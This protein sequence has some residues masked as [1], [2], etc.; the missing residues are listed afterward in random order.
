VAERIHGALADPFLV[1]GDEVYTTVSTGIAVSHDRYENP[2][3]MLRDAD[4]AMYQAK[5]D[6][7]AQYSVFRQAMHG[8]VVSQL[9]MENDLRRAL[10]R[11]EFELF[12]Q[13]IIDL[14]TR[15]IVACEALIRWRHPQRGLLLPGDF[16]V[17]AEDTG[18]IMP[19]G[20]WVVR[21]ACVQALEWSHRLGV[22]DSPAVSVNLFSTQFSRSELV[23]LIVSH[24]DDVGLPAHLLQLEITESAVIDVPEL[25]IDVMQRL[26]N[27]GVKVHLDDFGTGY[28]SL[29]YL[30]RFAIDVLKIDQSFIQR[31]GAAG[32]GLEIV[33]AIVNLARTLGMK[34]LAEGIE[35]AD[36]LSVVRDLGCAY[37]QG[38]YFARPAPAAEVLELIEAGPITL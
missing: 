24:L 2:D 33:K 15:T 9:H 30:Q 5:A 35:T 13:P 28:S 36:Q 31:L 17:H 29:S 32:D 1:G 14:D 16:L 10:D 38:F 7:R 34:A 3:E 8:M 22:D 12:Y 23:D 6:G 37:G 18:L 11:D 4:I 27:L 20:E 21:N 26:R 19:I 25:A